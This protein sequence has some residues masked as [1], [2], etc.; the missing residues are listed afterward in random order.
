MSF[1]QG[2]SAALGFSRERSALSS[3]QMYKHFKATYAAA[4]CDVSVNEYHQVEVLLDAPILFGTV[5]SLQLLT[6]ALQEWRYHSGGPRGKDAVVFLG[7]ACS[8]SSHFFRYRCC[9][10]ELQLTH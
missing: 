7:P 2:F 6:I 8:T 9:S 4:A 3:G 5:F 10:F 1:L